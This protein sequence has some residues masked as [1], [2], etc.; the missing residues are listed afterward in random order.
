ML[1]RQPCYFSFELSVES[2][3]DSTN[4]TILIQCI[5]H[6]QRTAKSTETTG[7]CGVFLYPEYENESVRTKGRVVLSTVQKAAVLVR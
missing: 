5:R 6:I 1:L 3:A 7:K 4:L 2:I